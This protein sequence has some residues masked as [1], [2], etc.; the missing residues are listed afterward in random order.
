MKLSVIIVNYNVRYFLEQALQSVCQSKTTFPFDVWVVDNTSADG[1]VE[2]VRSHFPEV[3]VIAN[4]ENVGFSRANNQAI[5]AS[6]GEYVLLLNPDTIIQEDTLQQVVDFMDTHA[7]AGGLGVKMIDGKGRYLPESKRGLPTPATALYKMLG[8]QRLFPGS[9]RFGRY[10]MSYLDPEQVQEVEVLS[11]ACMCLRRS[12]LAKTG[13]LDE[14][15]FMYGEDIDLSYRLLK[16]GYKNYYFPHTQIIHFKGESTRKDSFRYVILFYQA[17]IRFVQKH[18]SSSGSGLFILLIR[19]GIMLRGGLA[20]LRRLIERISWY[21]IDIGVIVGG[22]MGIKWLWEHYVKVSE[23][24]IYPDTYFYVNFPIYTGL[25]MLANWL[26]GVYD[27]PYRLYKIIIGMSIGTLFIAAVYGFLPMEYRS[28]RG[29]IVSSYLWSVVAMCGLRILWYTL[30][31]QKN[32]LFPGLNRV[33]VAGTF[34]DSQHIAGLMQKAGI[35]KEYLGFVSDS[36]DDNIQDGYL[37]NLSRLPDITAV[38]SPDEIIFSTRHTRG[39]TIMKYMAILGDKVAFKMAAEGSA[40]IVG[41]N[42]KDASGDIYTIDVGYR[43]QHQDQRRYKRLFDLVFSLVLLMFS[44]FVFLATRGSELWRNIVLVM[45]GK[46]SWVGISREQAEPGLPVVKPGVLTPLDTLNGRCLEKSVSSR[47]LFLYAREYSV[48][49]DME[50]LW[51]NWRKLGS[52][53]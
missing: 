38:L 18:F 2:M 28:S 25:W 43:I 47:I 31:G 9:R 41:S 30:S 15:F 16:A 5:T 22:M 7:D 46:K 27:K 34:K 12:A 45:L 33:I 6:T 48:A 13:L 20:T 14:D 3:Q 53:K 44:P 50:I 36:E 29:M 52:S 8:L 39:D 10:Y 4:T 49:R 17:M 24:I 37:G 32:Q 42:S 1:S 21:T 11:G 40:G 26:S 23:H 19:I 51:K 35:E